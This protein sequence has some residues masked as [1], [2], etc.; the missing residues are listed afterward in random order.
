MTSASTTL[1]SYGNNLVDIHFTTTRNS[2][3]TVTPTS[4]FVWCRHAEPHIHRH[5]F[6]DMCVHR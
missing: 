6:E 3:L 4:E 2:S 1:M 5:L